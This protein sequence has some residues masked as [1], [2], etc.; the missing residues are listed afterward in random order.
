MLGVCA[1]IYLWVGPSWDRRSAA[2]RGARLVRQ[3]QVVAIG[4]TAA[5]PAR[6]LLMQFSIPGWSAA[7]AHVT[8]TA[9]L[10]SVLPACRGSSLAARIPSLGKWAFSWCGQWQPTQPPLGSATAVT[11]TPLPPQPLPPPPPPHP[12][13]PTPSGSKDQAEAFCRHQQQG[14]RLPRSA[15]AAVSLSQRLTVTVAVP[16]RRK[17]LDSVT[18][19]FARNDA[20][21]FHGEGFLRWSADRLSVPCSGRSQS[22]KYSWHTA[23]G[24]VDCY[25]SSYPVTVTGVLA[26]ADFRV[27]VLSGF[28]KYFS[29]AYPG[30]GVWRIH[31]AMSR[32]NTS[33]SIAFGTF[34]QK[35]DIIW[36]VSYTLCHL[37]TKEKLSVSWQFFETHGVISYGGGWRMDVVNCDQC[38]QWSLSDGIRLELTDCLLV[39]SLWPHWLVTAATRGWTDH[40]P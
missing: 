4:T 1:C 6:C 40:S 13:T 23:L 36:M 31:S 11:A 28:I 17:R 12:P 27:G 8:R 20:K 38:T 9:P 2:G 35:P 29:E 15:C 22:R 18:D 25:V 26:I 19:E 37:S 34:L 21:L 3:Q 30:A 7:V 5:V 16:F 39:F 24:V 33:P 10:R 32:T 14:D